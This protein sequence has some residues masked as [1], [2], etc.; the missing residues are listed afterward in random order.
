V[1]NST[2]SQLAVL[3]LL[4]LCLVSLGSSLSLSLSRHGTLEWEGIDGSED[5]RR[6]E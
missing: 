3:T 5:K 1:S 2:S 4:A 6:K